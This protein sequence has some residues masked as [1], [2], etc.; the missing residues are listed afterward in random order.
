MPTIAVANDLAWSLRRHYELGQGIELFA[1][2]QEDWT[3][4]CSKYPEVRM[5]GGRQYDGI[6]GRI[7]RETFELAQAA[8]APIVTITNR[9]SFGFN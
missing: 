2:E 3:L 9:D 5:M 1:A 7:S 4:H 6:I 8:N